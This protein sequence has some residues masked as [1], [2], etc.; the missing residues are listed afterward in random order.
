MDLEMGDGLGNWIESKSLNWHI[1]CKK[2]YKWKFGQVGL[3]IAITWFWGN[4]SS[5][6]FQHGFMGLTQASL[7]RISLGLGGMAFPTKRFH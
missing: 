5:K 1:Q 4:T 3:A 6:H 7:T 2:S